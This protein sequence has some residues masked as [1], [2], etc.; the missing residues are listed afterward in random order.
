[1]CPKTLP[2]RCILTH[3]LKGT[4]GP[5]GNRGGDDGI[6]PTGSMGDIGPTG[7]TGDVGPSGTQG[8]D[9]NGWK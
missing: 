1:M 2:T 3:E 5:D 8:P 6:G 7:S 9:G 4:Q